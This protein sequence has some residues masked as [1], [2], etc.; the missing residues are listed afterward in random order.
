MYFSGHSEFMKGLIDNFDF[1]S[2]NEKMWRAYQFFKY[3]ADDEEKQTI[4]MESLWIEL[5]AGGI[6]PTHE[7]QV[8]I[9][10]QSTTDLKHQLFYKTDEN[11]P[12]YKATL[13]TTKIS[14]KMATTLK[15]LFLIV[16]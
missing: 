6:E 11:M 10:L 14:I 13:C 15:K 2:L 5:K 8:F 16:I 3:F 12:I 1:Q 4:S 9:F 7:R